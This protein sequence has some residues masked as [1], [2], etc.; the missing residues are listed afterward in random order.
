MLMNPAA[1][2]L[3]AVAMQKPLA[4]A[5]DL[6]DHDVIED[7]YEIVFG[8][9]A[10][11]RSSTCGDAVDPPRRQ[12][13]GSKSLKDT[14]I[15]CSAP[16]AAKLA[17]ST[18]ALLAP[19]TSA[20][21]CHVYANGNP[22][23]SATPVSRP[24]SASLRETRTSSLNGKVAP[25]VLDSNPVHGSTAA[26]NDAAAAR[27]EDTEAQIQGD[28]HGCEHNNSMRPRSAL[29]RRLSSLNLRSRPPSAKQ[30]VGTDAACAGAF[31]AAKDADGQAG[32]ASAEPRAAVMSSALPC[33]DVESE[34]RQLLRKPSP[35]NSAAPLQS[36]NEVKVGP[37]RL[38]PND[39]H[40]SAAAAKYATTMSQPSS[41]GSI[42]PAIA[43]STPAPDRPS[44]PLRRLSQLI[45]GS[46]KVP[47]SLVAPASL[48]DQRNSDGAGAGKRRP[49][50]AGIRDLFSRPSSGKQRSE[51]GVCTQQPLPK[52]A[53]K[54]HPQQR[55][56]G[57]GGDEDHRAKECVAGDIVVQQSGGVLKRAANALA[58]ALGR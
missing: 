56:S 53:W 32:R 33:V 10:L 6:A 36:K 31:R 4:Y 8:P 11:E 5:N 46:L 14:S 44:T 58:A 43:T 49:S 13:G 20:P 24:S 2:G 39:A 17:Q 21:D 41:R 23:I 40:D 29:L 18:S 51:T 19:R 47:G 12:L 26:Y 45:S 15:L 27:E 42:A 34:R 52:E 37:G 57:G 28:I 16:L 25:A 3:V 54:Q 48:P 55:Q 1:V 50:S 30:E 35:R 38:P 22:V 7:D 9:R